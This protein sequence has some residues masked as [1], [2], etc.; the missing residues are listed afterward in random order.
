M[1]NTKYHHTVVSQTMPASA[2]PTSV[3]DVRGRRRNRFC[4]AIGK[5]RMPAKLMHGHTNPQPIRIRQGMI[6]CPRYES[7]EAGAFSLALWFRAH[8]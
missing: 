5:H 1:I 3:D 8:A 6:L 2:G 7:G 4:G